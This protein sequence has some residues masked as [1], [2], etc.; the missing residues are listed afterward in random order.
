MMKML[1]TGLS[2]IAVMTSCGGAMT[3]TTY[4]A[5]LSGANEVPPV[6]T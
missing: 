2:L 5:T 4:N 3:T 6:T 1:L